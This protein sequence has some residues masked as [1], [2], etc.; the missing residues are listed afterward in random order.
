[1]QTYTDPIRSLR[2]YE[3]CKEALLRNRL[4]VAL[5]GCIESQKCHFAY[6]LGGEYKVRLIVT[7]NDL[8]AK[9]IADDFR[10]YDP[11][12]LYYPAKDLI[13]FQADIH[14]NT[15]IRER[16]RV[17]KRLS[18]NQPVTIVTTMNAGLDRVLPPEKIFEK[19]IVLK[20]TDSVELSELI[21]KLTE[22]GY[23]RQ[24]QVEHP[25]EFAVRGGILDVF[26]LTEETPYRI[27][28][29]GDDVDSIRYFD[30]TNQRSIDNLSEI[31]IFP[32]TEM[33]LSEKQK[34]DGIA[35]M[36]EEAE[37]IS[38]ALRKEMKTEEAARLRHETDDLCER[39]SCFGGL[40]GVDMCIRYFYP[41]TVSF[42]DYFGDETIV[43][44]D[45]P[46][47]I[48]ETVQAVQDEF[49]M[50]MSGRLEKGYILPGQADLLM[51]YKNVFA[52]FGKKKTFYLSVMDNKVPVLPPVERLDFTVRSVA[53]YNNNFELLVKDLSA[54]KKSGY[55]VILLC[56]SKLRAEHLAEELRERELTAFFSED[57]DRVVQK[58]EIYVGCGSVHRG[59]EY[60]MAKW[61]LISESD[62]FGPEH[63]KRKKTKQR[64]GQQISS[65]ND[66]VFGDYV[67]H[68]NHGLGIYRGIE[69]IEVEHVVKDYI[70]IE[71][72]DGGNLYVPATG[73]DVIQKYASA[74][75]AKKPKLNKLGSSEWKTTKARVK[76]AV[77]DLAKELVQ[78]YALRSTK[79]GFAC[80]AD[81]VWQTELEE[82]FPYDETDDQ[83]RAVEEIKKDMESTKIMDRLLCGDVGYGKTEVA[84]R[85]AFKA[86]SNGKQ[87]VVLVP[88]TILAQQ[89]YNTF[90]Q[91]MMS[92]PV[93]IEM[94]S[95]FRTP[96]QQK[97]ALEG[98]ERGTVDILIGT[99][100]VLSKDVHPKNLGLLIV[101]E[102]QRFGVAHKEKIKQLK[103][104]VDVLTLT[105]TPIPRTLHMS[106]IGI[107]DM[108]LL[109]EP[110]VDRLP[111]Q[112]YVMEQNDEM[113]REAICRELARGGQ[114]Y[115]V[116]NRV[117]GIDEVASSLAKMLPEAN[118][119]YA[120]GQMSERTLEKIMVDFINGD[121]DVLVS[122]T[123][124][125]TGLDISNVNTMIISDADRLGLSQLYQLRGRVGRTNRTAYA[126]LMYKRDKMLKEV[127]EKRLQ[128]I[129]EFTEL[130]SGYKIAMRDLEIRGAGNLL[131]AQQ[132]GHMEAVGYDLYCKLLNEA[133]REQKGETLPLE[134]FDTTVEI[135][136][137]AYIPEAYI[138]NE[139]Q[140]LDMYKR[141]ALIRSEEELEELQDELLDRFGNI[142]Q[143]VLKLLWVALV[144]S[145]AH[146]V[147]VTVL[148]LK[149]AELSLSWCPLTGLDTR[150]IGDFLDCYKDSMTFS[151]GKGPKFV[152]RLRAARG[153]AGGHVDIWASFKEI[154]QVLTD[155]KEKLF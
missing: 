142:P 41:N 134:E 126:F 155:M 76:G 30:V 103:G 53:A 32:A 141:I 85:A 57:T 2:E 44:L 119:A 23:E 63:K 117:H 17:I 81:T 105:A 60:P 104:D 108:S 18:E 131:G 22:L 67:V 74:E 47:R 135:D 84:L 148:S 132:S 123:I 110:P 59:F 114:V 100:R 6:A 39:I 9:E 97:K 107:R 21:Q 153:K 86:V 90:T 127:A 66:L 137:D 89:H 152:Y 72:G 61:A 46:A 140:K 49:T 5:T 37:K 73:L 15:L 139:M 102:E 25:G 79:K 19:K 147:Y 26:A 62:I 120:H 115:Y 12:V 34:E 10:L 20:D 80:E 150:K 64:D 111:I 87:V 52:G 77:R 136:T 95:R 88:T 91:R 55:R 154:K 69:K 78:L 50:S 128:A 133:V 98:F 94:M 146:E 56:A 113:V 8:K 101:D 14:G 42:F 125:E 138:R 36:K 40:G 27:E 16:M 83:L 68:E 35:K 29:F 71:Y 151:G 31:T 54:W 70:K 93:H 144:K 145:M 82:L 33:I 96:A 112:T 109:E 4:P 118:I 65:L 75:A 11:N 45:E 51:D 99:H 28:F 106:M 13:F 43:F 130:G 149:G 129:K 38:A 1:M 92:F 3:E 24:G 121:I 143:S 122:T 48:L 116:Y 58:G 124:I 7:Y